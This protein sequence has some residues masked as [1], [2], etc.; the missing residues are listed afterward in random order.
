MVCPLS[1]FFGWFW[2]FEFPGMEKFCKFDFA[3]VYE[4]C[5][6]SHGHFRLELK[7]HHYAAN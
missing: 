4:P 6:N 1:Y 5:L 7:L 3:K 2:K